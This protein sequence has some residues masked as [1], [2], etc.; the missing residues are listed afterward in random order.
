M[1]YVRN[2]LMGEYVNAGG[3][4][5]IGRSLGGAV[6][7]QVLATDKE[8]IVDGAVLENTFTSIPDMV[9]HIFAVVKHVK[10]LI[11]R[12]GW[13]TRDI[14]PSVETPMLFITGD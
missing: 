7:A 5:V 9:D 13:H 12:I 1:S 10:G 6:A 3:V 8:G 14:V 4:F 11:L 2:E